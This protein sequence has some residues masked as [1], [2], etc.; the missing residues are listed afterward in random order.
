MLGCGFE[1]AWSVFTGI[2][3]AWGDSGEGEFETGAWFN[4]SY[5]EEQFRFQAGS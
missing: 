2:L 4:L 5:E 3:A 1:F